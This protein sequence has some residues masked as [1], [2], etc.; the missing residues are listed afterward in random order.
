MAHGEM[1]WAF[2]R[3]LSKVQAVIMRF[4]TVA[5]GSRLNEP[6]AR[7]KKRPIAE[8]YGPLGVSKFLAV[9]C[10]IAV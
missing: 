1:P 6:L 10:S 5:A 4:G 3:N 9:K 8:C 2:R 7:K